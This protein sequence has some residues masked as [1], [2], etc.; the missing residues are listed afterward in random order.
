MLHK[1]K[2]QIQKY[3]KEE[4]HSNCVRFADVSSNKNN[5]HNLKF[6]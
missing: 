5:L 4:K 6:V 3:S 2:L 1:A